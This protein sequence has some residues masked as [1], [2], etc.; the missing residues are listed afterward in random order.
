MELASAGLFRARWTN[1]IHDEWI[2]NVLKNRP[3]I[4]AEQLDR[5]RDNMNRAVLGCLVDGHQSLIGALTLPDAGDRH[6]LA[7]A[8]RGSA[9]AIIT[10]NLKHFPK[11]ELA[12]YEIEA[13]HPDEFLHHQFGLDQASMIAAAQRIRKR[14]KNPPKT[15]EE[16]LDTLEAQQLPQTVAAL[17]PHAG[18]I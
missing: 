18:V 6:V 10:A 4:T 14:L 9:D 12:K 17:I 2:R 13:L 7:A 5:A 3:D 11:A 15:A 1:Q 8:I 16:Y